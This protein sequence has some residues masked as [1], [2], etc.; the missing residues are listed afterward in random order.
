M[1]KKCSRFNLEEVEKTVLLGVIC[2]EILKSNMKICNREMQN[3]TNIIIY[4]SAAIGSKNKH[5]YSYHSCFVTSPCIC[6]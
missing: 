2:N 4:N 3:V 1:R 6:Y 5:K